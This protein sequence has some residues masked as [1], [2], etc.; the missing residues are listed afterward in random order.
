MTPSQIVQAN[1]ERL[2]SENTKVDAKSTKQ[3]VIKLKNPMMLAKKSN[4]AE[5]KDVCYAL[6]CKDGLFSIDDI[7]STLL[8]FVTNLL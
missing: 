4:L 7:S 1:K 6:I 5:I 2:A 3:S 8:S